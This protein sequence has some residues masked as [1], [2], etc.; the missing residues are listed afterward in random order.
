MRCDNILKAFKPVFQHVY[1]NY[2]GHRVQPGEKMYMAIE[3][4]EEF[5]TDAGLINDICVV[6]DG[7]LCLG[8]SMLTQVN[9]LDNKRHIQAS[10]IEFLEAY[11]RIAEK[12]S[13]PPNSYGPLLT[14]QT[15]GEPD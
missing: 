9:E 2:G 15:D 11:V 7:S 6:R 10:F 14:I 1:K 5:V 13:V 4:F 8:L 3:E 12:A